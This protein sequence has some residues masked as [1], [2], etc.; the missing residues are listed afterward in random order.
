[1]KVGPMTGEIH[2]YVKKR[3]YTL[4]ILNNHSTFMY[5]LRENNPTHKD[6]LILWE[7]VRLH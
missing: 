7:L 3:N 4:K 5:L 6:L 2:L 1:M